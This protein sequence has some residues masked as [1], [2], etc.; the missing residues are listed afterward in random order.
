MA[1]SHSDLLCSQFTLACFEPTSYD[2]VIELT[3]HQMEL[4]CKHCG[5]KLFGALEHAEGDWFI[6]C[7]TCGVKNVIAAVV[8]IVGWRIENACGQIV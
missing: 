3:T 8:Q 5:T 2:A 6:P 1:R 4:S 7:F